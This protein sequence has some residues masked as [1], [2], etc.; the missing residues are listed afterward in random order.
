M[1]ENSKIKLEI[2][3]IETNNEEIKIKD[4]KGTK[5]INSLN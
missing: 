5:I 2:N 3:V 1:R 4:F